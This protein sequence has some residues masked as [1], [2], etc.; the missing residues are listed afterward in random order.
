[1]GIIGSIGRF[2]ERGRR[3]YCWEDL[4]SFDHW[5]SGIIANGLRECK[6]HC[7][8]YPGEGVTGGEWMAIEGKKTRRPNYIG[9]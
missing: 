2:I 7:S 6:N 8:A 9:D 4:W 5:L 1:M 3:G